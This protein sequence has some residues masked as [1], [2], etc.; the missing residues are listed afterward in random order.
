[1]K[2][3]ILIVFLVAYLGW[4]ALSSSF[5][6]SSPEDKAG[7]DGSFTELP[8]RL[9]PGV[10]GKKDIETHAIQQ[11]SPPSFAPQVPLPPAGQYM[12][13]DLDKVDMKK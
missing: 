10:L 1:M 5:S 4:G 2:G 6:A 3:V 11:E 9:P 13:E 12:R 8:K 7:S